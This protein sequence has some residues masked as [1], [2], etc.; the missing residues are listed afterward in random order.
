MDKTKTVQSIKVLYFDG[1]GIKGLKFFFLFQ[2]VPQPSSS[3]PHAAGAQVAEK[4]PA[5]TYDLH[6]W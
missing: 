2:S 6:Q 1:L 3:E 4:L 5:S